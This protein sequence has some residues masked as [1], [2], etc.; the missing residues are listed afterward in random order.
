MPHCSE[1]KEN[2]SSWAWVLADRR[3][4]ARLYTWLWH[5][6]VCCCLHLCFTP[7]ERKIS[8]D[9]GPA[10]SHLYISQL[11]LKLILKVFSWFFL[12][13]LT[14]TFG[15]EERACVS[16]M[17]IMAL[18]LTVRSVRRLT[19]TCCPCLKP[20][21]N[22]TQVLHTLWITAH[23]AHKHIKVKPCT[24]NW[25]VFILQK[26]LAHPSL[27]TW[28]K[29]SHPPV[30]Q[31]ALLRPN[32]TGCCFKC[33]LFRCG[34]IYC[35]SFPWTISAFFLN[36]AQVFPI[37]ALNAP[38]NQQLHRSYTDYFVLGLSGD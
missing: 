16:G 13:L 4:T 15:L 31:R 30:H 11:F 17:L 28:T 1:G 12:T 26:H 14:L 8:A 34:N 33:N 6:G 9:P 38:T 18:W 36:T 21:N 5:T 29:A 2:R 20:E 32:Q 37:T 7:H 23:V 10:L 22:R 24:Y 35:C 25:S 3:Q 19:V 27:R